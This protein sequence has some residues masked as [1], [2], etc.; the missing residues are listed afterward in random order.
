[1]SAA[2]ALRRAADVCEASAIGPR[3]ERAIRLLALYVIR[4]CGE[5]ENAEEARLL[6]ELLGD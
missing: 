5:G 3:K 6:C 2:E 1:M 4:A